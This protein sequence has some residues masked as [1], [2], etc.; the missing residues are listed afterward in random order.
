MS[1]K[2][3]M[4]K[5]QRDET[6]FWD[7]IMTSHY[8]SPEREL[9]SIKAAL[10]QSAIVAI[11]DRAGRIIHVNDK[12]CEISKYPREELLGQTH[13]LINSGYHPKEFFVSMWRKISRGEIWQGEVRN[14]A[15]DGTYYW[16][17]TTIVPF[18]NPSGEPYQYVSIRFE[19]TSQKEAE[20]KLQTYAAQLERS[21]EALQERE[22][23]LQTA[24]DERVQMQAQILQQDRLASIGLLASSLAHEIG[25]P[26]GVIRGR[27]EYL[28]M[29]EKDNPLVAEISPIII[30]QIDRVSHLIRTLLT[31][32]RGED[33]ASPSSVLVR[34]VVQDVID[35]LGHECRR[36]G[37]DVRNEV[38]PQLAVAAVSGPLHQVFLNLLVNSLQAIQEA[39]KLAHV[40]RPHPHQIRVVSRRDE[41]KEGRS[42]VLIEVEDT[43]CGISEE[44]LGRLFTPFFTTKD[45]GQ[46]TGLGLA[47]SYRILEAWGAKISARS[48]VGQ[49]TTFTLDLVAQA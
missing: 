27:A 4:P 21:F 49:G 26:L 33:Q 29:K 14:R 39:K 28:L 5:K 23:K 17:Y 9:A 38:D 11:T 36:Q 1:A 12:F 20:A 41:N 45:I 22:E 30:G 24:L 37:I 8:V 19:I 6:E 34:P 15:K 31:L 10:E 43:G 18:L 2:A 46:G 42:R 40:S 44:N 47:T 16:V 7:E 48:V 35:L 25:T 32:A 3:P 13:R